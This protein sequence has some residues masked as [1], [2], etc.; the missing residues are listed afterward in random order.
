MV[1]N[2]SNKKLPEFCSQREEKPPIKSDWLCGNSAMVFSWGHGLQRVDAVALGDKVGAGG[3]PGAA[4]TSK[5]TGG[6]GH[7]CLL[8]GMDCRDLLNIDSAEAWN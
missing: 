1:L 5:G 3:S 6:G 8:P 4:A 2:A 7:S